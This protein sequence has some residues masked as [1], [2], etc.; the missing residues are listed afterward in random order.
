[1]VIVDGK[2]NG[3]SDCIMDSDGTP[4]FSADSKHI[5]FEIN[6]N[7]KQ[8]VMVDGQP[9]KEYDSVCKG[10]PFFRPGGVM[11]YLAIR[12]HSLFRVRCVPTQ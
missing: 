11:D 5:A 7:G 2:V 9:G 6:K 8:L 1:M 3:I 12:D 10:A 4:V